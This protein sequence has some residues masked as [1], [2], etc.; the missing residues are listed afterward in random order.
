MEEWKEDKA[1]DPEL[2]K[3]QLLAWDEDNMYL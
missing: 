2:W 3:E 1:I